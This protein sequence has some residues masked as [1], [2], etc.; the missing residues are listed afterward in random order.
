MCKCD[1]DI[2]INFK[3]VVRACVGENY[4]ESETMS[5]ALHN[6]GRVMSKFLY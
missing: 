1:Q 3:S 2:M 4:T 6:R 5:T